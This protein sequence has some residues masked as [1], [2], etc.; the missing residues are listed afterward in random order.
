[1]LHLS[2]FLFSSFVTSCPSLEQ[3]PFKMNLHV[4]S[5][6][7]LLSFSLSLFGSCAVILSDLHQGSRAKRGPL[8][9]N[10]CLVHSRVGVSFPPAQVLESRSKQL[11]CGSLNRGDP[12]TPEVLLK[13]AAMRPDPCSEVSPRSSSTIPAACHQSQPS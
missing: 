13:V 10:P 12:R 3:M 9:G 7:R 4:I 11:W 5:L 8:S 1:M 6:H 2:V